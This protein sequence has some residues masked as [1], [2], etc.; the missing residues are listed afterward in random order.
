MDPVIVLIAILAII[1]PAILFLIKLVLFTVAAS[2]V[3]SA[4]SPTVIVR[5]D[6]DHGKD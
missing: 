3:A 5:K 1:G 6:K 4:V 2:V